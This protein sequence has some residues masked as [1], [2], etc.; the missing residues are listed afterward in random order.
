MGSLGPG[1]SNKKVWPSDRRG[2]SPVFR[3]GVSTEFIIRVNATYARSRHRNKVVLA[4]SILYN[5]QVPTFPQVVSLMFII[6][7]TATYVRSGHRIKLIF[8]CW[9]AQYRLTVESRPTHGVFTQLIIIV[10]V[11]TTYARSGHWIIINVSL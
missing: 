10:R 7:V 3:R 8:M 1:L 9:P 4:G 2:V 5:S 11:N 6:R